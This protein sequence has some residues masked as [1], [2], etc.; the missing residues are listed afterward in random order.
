M[1]LSKLHALFLLVVNSLFY[2]IYNVYKT[3]MFFY[4][5]RNSKTYIESYI[6]V[7]LIKS[8]CENKMLIIQHV[9]RKTSSLKKIH[10]NFQ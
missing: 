7:R 6:F 10:T 9:S 2:N 4:S 1:L 5:V 8:K 3:R